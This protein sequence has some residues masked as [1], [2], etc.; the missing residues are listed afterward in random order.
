MT[1]EDM[2]SAVVSV[3]AE[4]P[5][6][7]SN[8]APDVKGFTGQKVRWFLNS[9]V[10]R[11]ST[12]HLEVGCY[13]G[14]TLISAMLDNCH[15]H[16]MGVEDFRWP[17][18]P[19]DKKDLHANLLKYK[20]RMGPTRLVEQDFFTFSWPDD[21]PRPNTIFYDGTHTASAQHDAVL[22]CAKWTPLP[23]LF[24]VDDWNWDG[25][26]K[27]TVSGIKEAGFDRITLWSRS[28][29]GWHNG[30]GI[31]LLDKVQK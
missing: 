28:G 21:W 24:I 26:H 1:F 5:E 25:P 9:I 7:L 11:I 6:T 17:G 22:R 31:Y 10:R 27:G 2:E 20:K 13:V 3:L 15:C 14:A 12:S 23:F 8:L 16:A 29:K 18:C 30:V 4:V 19:N